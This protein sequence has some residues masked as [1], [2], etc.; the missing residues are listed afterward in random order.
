MSRETVPKW[1]KGWFYGAAVYNVVWGAWVILFPGMFFD[2]VGM[3]RVNY[4]PIWQGVGMMVA[5]FGLGYYYIA[6][7]PER[8][9]NYVW[10]GILGK[11]FGPVGGI[12]GVLTG[13]LP[14]AFFWVFLLNDLIWWP[15]FWRFAFLYARKPLD[16]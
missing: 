10:I 9:G 13:Q 1:V 8:Y 16:S 3:E 14:V 15:V 2:L 4:L 12:Y 7:N 11:T 5:V 6:R